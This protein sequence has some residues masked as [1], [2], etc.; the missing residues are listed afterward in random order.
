MA[1]A[2]DDRDDDVPVVLP[3]LRF[4]RGHRL[5]GLIK[6]YRRAIVTNTFMNGGL[7]RSDAF[8][9]GKISVEP[10][11]P[12]PST[13]PPPPPRPG[14]A[15]PLPLPPQKRTRHPPPPTPPPP[16]PHPPFTLPPRSPHPP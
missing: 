9:A 12:S 5:L 7:R 3:G 13:T 6:G 4:G 14:G 2:V 8:A 11:P 10:P 1:A 15:R 16:H